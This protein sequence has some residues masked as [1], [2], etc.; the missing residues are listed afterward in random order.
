MGDWSAYKQL[1]RN[2]RL[3]KQFET[4]MIHAAPRSVDYQLKS[5]V[6]LMPVLL[7]AGVVLSIVTTRDFNA[8]VVF[9][10]I[11]LAIYGFLARLSGKYEEKR[12]HQQQKLASLNAEIEAELAQAKALEN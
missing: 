6:R 3:R 4:K 8:I 12:Q 9:V 11:S 1:P 7:V 5:M 10:L 2:H